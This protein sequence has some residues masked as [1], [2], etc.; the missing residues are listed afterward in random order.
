MLMDYG[1]GVVS[2]GNLTYANASAINMRVLD[3]LVRLAGLR[4]RAVPVTPIL[5]ERKEEL[6]KLLPGWE[7]GKVSGI[8]AVNFFE[9]YFEDALRKEA[10]SVYERIGKV[11]KVGEMR[12]E[13]NLRGSFLIEGE[14]GDAEVRFTLTPE[15]PALIQEYRIRIVGK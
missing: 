2:C 13:N 8:F 7:K 14:K 10:E 9:D 12:A 11:V 5:E 6:V 1:V 3:T 4:P 15:N